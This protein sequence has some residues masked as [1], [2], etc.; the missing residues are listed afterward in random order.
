VSQ[1]NTHWIYVSPNPGEF[2]PRQTEITYL[3]SER[4][5]IRDALRTGEQVLVENT[6]LLAKIYRG[7]ADANE[8]TSTSGRGAAR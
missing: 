8:R 6:L 7:A 5:L 1:D 3:G 2:E 4:V